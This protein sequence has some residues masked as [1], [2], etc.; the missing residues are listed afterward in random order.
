MALGADPSDVMALVFSR[1]LKPVAVGIA[2]GALGGF[3]FI[4]ALGSQFVVR[5]T[6]AD[7]LVLV[8]T[9]S[10]M[11]LVAL[12]AGFFPALQA[13]RSAPRVAFAEE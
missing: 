11:A 12:A 8:A 6:S 1:L 9:S 2:M 10:V 5:E 4:K 13:T 7:P 3:L